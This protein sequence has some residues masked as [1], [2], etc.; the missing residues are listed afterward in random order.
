[1]ELGF[2]L[3][4]EEMRYREYMEPMEPRLKVAWKSPIDSRD[5]NYGSGSRN[6]NQ[7]GNGPHN[8]YRGNQNGKGRR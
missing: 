6:N 4:Q 1:M 2:E 7:R 8:N 5:G 3:G